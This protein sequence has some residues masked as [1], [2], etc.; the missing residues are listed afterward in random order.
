MQ[1]MRRLTQL[2]QDFLWE[3]Q[4]RMSQT[5][6]TAV[7]NDVPYLSQFARREDV[8]VIIRKE[9]ATKDD[10]HWEQ[11]GAT[12]PDEYAEWSW[13]M[14]G[15][16]CTAMVLGALESHERKLLDLAIDALQ[17]GVYTRDKNSE[18]SDMKYREFTKWARRHGLEAC[19]RAR[20][21]VAGVKLAIARGKFPIVSV[22]PN[23][24][25]Y[26]TAS[27]SKKGGHL[28]LVTGYDQAKRVLFLHNPSGFMSKNTQEYEILEKDFL[29]YYAGRGVIVGSAV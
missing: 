29:K 17:H 21:S 7:H 13:A 10:P 3:L 26:K 1:N 12:S 25:G 15:M 11:S 16:A 20:L 6:E 18:L 27:S 23:I 14:C 8:E 24:R 2:F 4:A 19:V 22:N 5:P 9:L 28:V